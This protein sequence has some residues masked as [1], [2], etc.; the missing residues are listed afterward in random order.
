MMLSPSKIARNERGAALIEF[1][2]AAPVLMMFILGTLQAGLM[3]RANSALRQV[4]GEAG[5]AAMVSYQDT[6]DGVLTEDQV[7][8]L[9]YNTATNDANGLKGSDLDID[10]DITTDP[11][12]LARVI[13]I[14]LDYD[15]NMS[16]PFIGDRGL[17]VS[18][19]RQFFAPL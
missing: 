5:R 13:T 16:I 18:E 8:T 15:V 4:I 10:V 11:A 2:F 19:R 12:I 17:T 3:L 9:V 7:R 14:D 1:A 6:S